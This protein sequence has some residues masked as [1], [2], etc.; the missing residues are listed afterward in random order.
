MVFR[1]RFIDSKFRSCFAFTDGSCLE[2]PGPCGAGAVIFF[3]DDSRGLELTR[4]VAEKGSIIL[5]ELKAILMVLERA[6]CKKISD[7]SSLQVLSDSQSA[8][9]VLTLNLASANFTVLISQIKSLLNQLQS[10][11]FEVSLHWTLG[12]ATIAGWDQNC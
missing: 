11:A 4:P 7:F 8:V 1:N 6:V 12:H 3:P 2:N 10:T 5:A 9:G